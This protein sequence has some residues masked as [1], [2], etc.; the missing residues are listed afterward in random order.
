LKIETE[1]REDHQINVTVELE[2]VQLESARRKVARKIAQRVKIPGFRPGKAPYDVVL[3]TVGESSIT[4]DAIEFL[5]D[6]TYPKILEQAGIKAAAP[7]SL[8]DVISMDPPKFKFLIP[9]SPTVDLGDFRSIQ[10]KYE[11][12]PPQESAVSEAIEELRRMYS[13]TE[14]VARE[15]QTGDFVLV[16]V[17]GYASKPDK[18]EKPILE[19]LGNPV[20]IRKDEKPDEWPFNGFSKELIGKKQDE[21]ASFSHRYSKE[22]KDESLRGKKVNF[23]VKIKTVRGMILPE[24]DDDFAKKVGNFENVAMLQDAVHKNLDDQSKAEYEDEYFETLIGSIKE[25]AT[26]KYPPQLLSHESEHVLDDLKRRIAEQ[27]LELDVYLKMRGSDLDKFMQEEVTPVAIRRLERSLIM[28]QIALEEKIEVSNEDLNSSFQQT[29]SEIQEDEQF[30][31]LSKT[32]NPSKKILES[33]AFESANRVMIRKTLERMKSIAN[34][35][36][37]S[38]LEVRTDKEKTVKRK[39]KKKQ[40]QSNLSPTSASEID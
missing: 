7:G 35:E 38:S 33:V 32:K 17:I 13:S 9:L 1:T 2:P 30:K 10:Q 16:D 11:W 24:L 26:I 37:Q 25:H 29:W 14:S 34:G 20:F 8:E 5:V 31:K 27:N 36:L 22:D 19:K 40:E 15:I 6:E 28:D 4:E 21:I 39:T 18:D 12:Q 23:E 3:R